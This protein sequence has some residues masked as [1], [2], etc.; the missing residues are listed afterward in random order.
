MLRDDGCWNN[1]IAIEEKVY[2]NTST[3]EE[4]LNQIGK[5]INT[6]GDEINQLYEMF[7]VSLI[8]IFSVI[9]DNF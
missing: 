6:L 8:N 4:Q 3:L 1:T 7:D 9:L 5:T 2:D